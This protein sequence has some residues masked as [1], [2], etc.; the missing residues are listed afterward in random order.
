MYRGVVVLAAIMLL[1][2]GWSGTAR[3]AE[4]DPA[5]VHASTLTLSTGAR[6]HCSATAVA[7][8]VLLTAT[9]CM[10][11]VTKAKPLHVEGVRVGIYRRSDDGYDHTLLTLDGVVFNAPA[12]V[13]FDATLQ[14][15]EPI[16]IVGNPG[17]YRD[18]VRRGY[19]AGRYDR[20]CAEEQ[21]M[22]QS[23]CRDIADIMVLD[24]NIFGG[25]SGS[26]VFDRHGRVVG[27]T[28][29]YL[30]QQNVG[31]ARVFSMAE[32]YPFHF[33]PDQLRQHGLLKPPPYRVQAIAR[34]GQY[35]P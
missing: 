6:H 19:V 23:E 22:L 16:M 18:M 21:Y 24:L 26:A 35:A 33:T 15:G 29:S 8:Q 11:R 13:A 27:L 34:A 10:T 2:V 5:R 7:P 28:S 25:D 14:Q 31:E 9:H 30:A 32:V 20:I 12:T 3:I 17:M 4:A 1:L